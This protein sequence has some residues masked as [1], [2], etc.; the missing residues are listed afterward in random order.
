MKI[1]ILSVMLV[2]GF[3][4]GVEL[5]RLSVYSQLESL[6]ESS[7]SSYVAPVTTGG[8]GF[9]SQKGGSCG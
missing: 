2:I 7:D 5:K 3:G 4:V 1:I 8:Q 9:N 6:V